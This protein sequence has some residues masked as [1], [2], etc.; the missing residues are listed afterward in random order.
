[1]ELVNNYNNKPGDAAERQGVG[2]EAAVLELSGSCANVGPSWE[3]RAGRPGREEAEM[4]A[5]VERGG[6][7]QGDYTLGFWER[8]A[9]E[10]ATLVVEVVEVDGR[11]WAGGTEM[12]VKMG[13]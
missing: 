7:P 6:L 12:V 11:C 1:M 8:G 2:P 10:V 5:E 4:G 3:F 13:C 9:Q